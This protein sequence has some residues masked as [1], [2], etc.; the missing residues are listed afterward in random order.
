[1]DRKQSSSRLIVILEIILGVAILPCFAFAQSSPE[2]SPRREFGSSL[3]QLKWDPEKRIAIETKSRGEKPGNNAAEDVIRVETE[4]VVLEVEVSDSVTES[5]V[6]GLTHNDF[7]LTV[8]GQP[9]QIAHFSVGDYLNVPRSE[10][11]V[12]GTPILLRA[13]SRRIEFI[14]TWIENNRGLT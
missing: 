1:M 10:L 9:Q 2:Q 3:K 7:I 5:F 14:K 12:M 6:R 4:L 11:L 8:D 13:R